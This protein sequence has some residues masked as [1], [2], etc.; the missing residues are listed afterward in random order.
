[1]VPSVG[2]LARISMAVGGVACFEL[3][4]RAFDLSPPTIVPVDLHADVERAAMIGP[5]CRAYGMR[6]RAPTGFF[7]LLFLQSLWRQVAADGAA[8]DAVAERLAHI[9]EAEL[10]RGRENDR[11]GPRRERPR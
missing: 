3:L 9:D 4:S 2:G 11:T 6:R 1:V 7:A 10:Q 5:R 8:L